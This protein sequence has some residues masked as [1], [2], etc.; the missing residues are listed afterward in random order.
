MEDGRRR[1]R[2]LLGSIRCVAGGKIL[3]DRGDLRPRLHQT[4]RPCRPPWRPLVIADPGHERGNRRAGIDAGGVRQ[5]GRRLVCRR[6]RLLEGPLFRAR[7]RFCARP[8]HSPRCPPGCYC[9]S[10]RRGDRGDRLRRPPKAACRR[11]V[12]GAGARRGPHPKGVHPRAGLSRSAG[13]AGADA[14]CRLAPRLSQFR[15]R[16][17][18][19][20]HARSGDSGSR[21]RRIA[22]RSANASNSSRS[23]S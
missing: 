15:M 8:R 10:A 6:S 4:R 11:A 22:A 14:R 3:L 20:Q 2:P 5:R 9:A 23:T 18:D 16:G 19:Q 1:R 12:A 17:G 21:S 13:D 7:R